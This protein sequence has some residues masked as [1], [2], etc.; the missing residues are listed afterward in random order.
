MFG[1][2]DEERQEV[3]ER[4]PWETLERRARDPNRLVIAV[5]IAVALGALAF[6]FVR[7]QP[8]NPT[9]PPPPAAQIPVVPTQPFEPSPTVSTPLAVAE[10][11]LYAV[12]EERLV[13]LAAAH[14]EWFAVEF[15]A[16]DGSEHSRVTLASLLPEGVPVPEAA[17]GIQ[18]FVDWVRASSVSEMSALVYQ[19]EVIVRSL[20]SSPEGGFVRQPTRTVLIDVA[21]GADGSPRVIRPPAP[22]DEPR[23][24]PHTLVLSGVPEHI[25]ESVESAYG[26]VVGGEQ[27]PGGGY[28]VVAM[29]TDA[30]GVTRPRTVVVP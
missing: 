24:T 12:D 14:A 4:I 8:V 22:M 2:M 16:V 3:Y 26:P 7:N 25:R 19:V 9:S 5:A 1:S 21:I 20:V 28:R 10:A 6:S 13:D 15:F 23:P 27:L 17:P 29:V 18:V 30:D 11:D